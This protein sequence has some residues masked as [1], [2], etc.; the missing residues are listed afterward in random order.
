MR[1]VRLCVCVVVLAGTTHIKA[2]DQPVEPAPVAEKEYGAED[3]SRAIMEL[4]GALAEHKALQKVPEEERAEGAGTGV[5][6]LIL[7]SVFK[8]LLSGVSMT[9][10]FWRGRKGKNA[11]KV[12]T[13]ALGTGVMLFSKMAIGVS[14]H[15]AVYLALSG[16][17]AIVIHEIT[18][19]FTRKE[20][21]QGANA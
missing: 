11:L 1:L 4:H 6:V 2:A 15:E 18:K 21:P 13:L 8:I 12:L 3:L 7:S 16:P 19:M 17:G 5:I 20:E 9:G 14:W 10:P